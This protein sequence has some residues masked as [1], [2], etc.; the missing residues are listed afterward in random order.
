MLN[1]KNVA[2]LFCHKFIM[3]PM[4]QLHGP[5]VPVTQLLILCLR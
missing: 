5:G 1:Q 4:I 2:A 3:L